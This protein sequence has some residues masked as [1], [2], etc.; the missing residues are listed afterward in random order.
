LPKQSIQQQGK[1][2]CPADVLRRRCDGLSKDYGN[3]DK[4]GRPISLRW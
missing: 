4:K 1:S 2:N 3:W